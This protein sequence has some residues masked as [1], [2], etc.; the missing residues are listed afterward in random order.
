MKE[1][2]L[3]ESSDDGELKEDVNVAHKEGGDAEVG[4]VVEG[5]W[6]VE[7]S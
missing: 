1:I 3:S 6:E 7:C 4:G 5:E 2:L